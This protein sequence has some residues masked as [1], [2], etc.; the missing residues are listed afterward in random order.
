MPVEII[1]ADS[2]HVYTRLDVASN[3]PSLSDRARVPHHL[4]DTLPPSAPNTAGVW[5]AAARGAVEDVARRGRTPLVVGGTMMYLRWL[6]HGKPATPAPSAASVRVVDEMLEAVK[7]DWGGALELLAA[8][9]PKRAT[10]LSSNDWYRLRRSLQIVE[11]TGREAILTGTRTG[12]GDSSSGAQVGVSSLPVVGGAPGSGIP[13]ED[14][15]GDFRCFFLFDDR[16]SLN[17]RIDRRCERMI[18]PLVAGGDDDHAPRTGVSMELGVDA[19]KSI[20]KEV[21]QLLISRAISTADG[22]PARAIGYRQTILYLL[23]RALQYSAAGAGTAKSDAV[24][25]FRAYVDDFQQATRGYAKQQIQWFRKEPGYIWVRG[26]ADSAT[27]LANLFQLGESAYLER[28]CSPDFKCEQAQ[29][30][31]DMIAQGKAMKTYIPVKEVLVEGSTEEK[32]AVELSESL[33]SDIYG[34]LGSPELNRF[35]REMTREG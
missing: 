23:S 22:S 27:D 14:M 9:D 4:I 2:V 5:L 31:T 12:S 25:A 18:L 26:G 34:K 17:R 3:K 33:A 32:I 11:E 16:I 29:M 24:D 28:V 35:V 10:Q 21:A 8:K 13:R 1:S 7:G 15:K 20:L 30:R 6:L 19:E